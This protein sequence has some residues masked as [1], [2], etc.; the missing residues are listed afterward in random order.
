MRQM[1]LLALLIGLAAAQLYEPPVE[2]VMDYNGALGQFL[3]NRYDDATALHST[4]QIQFNNGRLLPLPVDASVNVA[5]MSLMLDNATYPASGLSLL[6]AKGARQGHMWASPGSPEF[7]CNY[8]S[9]YPDGSLDTTRAQRCDFD[10][11]GCVE[12]ELLAQVL[13]TGTVAFTFK[14]ATYSTPFTSSILPLS[15]STPPGILAQMKT[16]SGAD[17]LNASIVGTMRFIYYINDREDAGCADNYHYFTK[18]VSFS[19]SRDFTVF[20][21]NKLYFLRAPVLREQ[22]F[23]DNR[24]DT[25]ILSQGPLYHADI[26]LNGNRTRNLTLRT[27]DTRTGPYGIQEIISYPASPDGWSERI[28]L[29]TP[30]QLESRNYSFAYTYEFSYGYEGLGQNVLSIAV[31]GPALDDER[32]DEVILSRALSYNG[33]TAETG[34]PASSVPSRPSAA[35]QQDY[36]ASMELVLGLLALLFL[37]SFVNLWLL[38]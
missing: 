37:L 4:V 29:A 36:M 25:I 5:G 18:N 16:S 6:V 13:Y 1:L 14:N 8:S 28:G 26:Y 32:H 7:I 3:D 23:R 34:E 12:Y 24:F 27:F 20:G 35:F 15:M 30:T 9:L 31:K 10:Q 33:A 11:D 19:T 17:L 2:S 38:K 21:A 22:W